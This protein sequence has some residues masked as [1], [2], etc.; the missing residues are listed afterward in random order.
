MFFFMHS[1]AVFSCI[2]RDGFKMREI[3]WERELYIPRRP[4]ASVRWAKLSEDIILILGNVF[5][6][7]QQ[8]Q[9]DSI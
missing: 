6:H 8:K 9:R 7:T 1:N 2:K 4:N 3:F 5:T